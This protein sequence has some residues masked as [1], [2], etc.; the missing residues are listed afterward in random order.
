LRRRRWLLLL[1]FVA[2]MAVAF[3]VG[4]LR[5]STSSAESIHF[6]INFPAEGKEAGG[7]GPMAKLGFVAA[8]VGKTGFLKALVQPRVVNFSSHWVRNVGDRPIRVRLEMEGIRSPVRWDSLDKDWDEETRS[9]SRPLAP[10]ETVTVDWYITI[11]DPLPAGSP[12]VEKGR[13]V[14]YDADTGERLSVLPLSIM[15]SDNLLAEQGEGG[16]GAPPDAMGGT[17]AS[18]ETGETTATTDE[19][20]TSGGDC[21][22]P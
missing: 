5:Q 17:P 13:I 15:N 8:D 3:G 21:C 1:W 20:A 18:G 7:P 14:I 22:A 2:A 11:P 10:G 6:S 12:V 4:A 9:I 16:G 19:A